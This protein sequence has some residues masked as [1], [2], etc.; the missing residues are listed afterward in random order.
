M[1]TYEKT[2]S[3]VKAN[4]SDA[5]EYARR[6]QNVLS[7][8]IKELA[9]AIISR[10]TTSETAASIFTQ[11]HGGMGDPEGDTTSA[12]IFADTTSANIFAN[13]VKILP[14]GEPVA[15]FSMY[16]SELYEKKYGSLPPSGPDFPDGTSSLRDDDDNYNVAYMEGRASDIAAE[17]FARRYGLSPIQRDK[18]GSV[19]DAVI[20]GDARYS[21][22]PVRSTADGLL[23]PFY[24][25]IEEREM[26]ILSETSVSTG[27]SATVY[28]LCGRRPLPIADEVPKFCEISC[29][30]G[31]AGAEEAL[32]LSRELNALGHTVLDITDTRSA[33]GDVIYRFRAELSGDFRPLVVCLNLAHP[34]AEITGL[35]STV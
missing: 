8:T 20:T 32:I 2:V 16:F 18:I 33:D 19:C 31:E 25:A 27:D 28:A 12:N 3:V 21:I 9:R 26:K 34:R 7:G 13:V 17:I 30:V 4:L 22:V 5:E 10:E 24:R 29:D 1:M 11:R 35:Y 6:G 14:P 15:L 23:K